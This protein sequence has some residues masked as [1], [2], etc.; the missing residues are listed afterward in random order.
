VRALA[1]DLR[2]LEARE[3]APDGVRLPAGDAVPAPGSAV[4]G[5]GH[6]GQNTQRHL[7]SNFS[8]QMLED[9]HD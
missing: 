5:A 8:R 4:G 1:L 3:S 7:M 9:F 2:R 6:A